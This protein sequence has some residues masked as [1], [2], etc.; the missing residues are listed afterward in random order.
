MLYRPNFNSRLSSSSTST[1]G[2]GGGRGRGGNQDVVLT[3][4]SASATTPTPPQVGQLNLISTLKVLY[5]CLIPPRDNYTNP[6]IHFEAQQCYMYTFI[7]WFIL[8]FALLMMLTCRQ[9]TRHQSTRHLR[10][11]Q[12]RRGRGL[13]GCSGSLS[14]EVSGVLHFKE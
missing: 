4:F 13:P 10:P 5:T 11:T 9:T 12:R 14:G 6:T 7:D 2:R 8:L 3:N 1:T